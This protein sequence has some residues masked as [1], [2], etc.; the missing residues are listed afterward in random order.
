MR[1]PH[2]KAYLFASTIEAKTFYDAATV[3]GLETSLSA[4]AVAFW[5]SERLKIETIALEAFT[6]PTRQ[7]EWP[8]HIET[9]EPLVS[10]RHCLMCG[11]KL[12]KP[13][14]GRQAL[15][16]MGCWIVLVGMSWQKKFDIFTRQND[17]CL[18]WRG[19]VDLFNVPRMP[20]ANNVY[21]G[22]LQREWTARY[23]PVPPRHILRLRCRNSLCVSFDHMYSHNVQNGGQRLLKMAERITSKQL[24]EIKRLVQSGEKARW[25]IGP[26]YN[27]SHDWVKP[28]VEDTMTLVD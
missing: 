25:Q 28:I 10:P 7:I 24:Q 4:K 16:S 11:K 23:G 3:E 5:T 19:P 12:A 27:I 8:E 14:T 15:C 2:R 20:E 18:E 13:G 9:P 17:E 1:I 6:L 21:R 22:V 26:M